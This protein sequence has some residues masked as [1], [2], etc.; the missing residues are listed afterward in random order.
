MIS[1]RSTHD[2]SRRRAV[3]AAVGA[4]ATAGV[5]SSLVAAPSGRAPSSGLDRVT[6]LDF[7]GSAAVKVTMRFRFMDPLP[8]YPATYL[9]WAYPRRQ[10]GYYTAFFWGNDD[11]R[12]DLRTFLWTSARTAD[13]YYGAHP[14]PQPPPRGTNHRWEISVLQED[15]VNGVV[16]YDRWHCQA[17]RVWADASGK[18]HEFY[19]D[20]PLT[21][22]PHRVAYKAPAS[23]GNVRPP[24]PTL[25]WGDAP[26]AP[27]KEVWNGV[28]RGIQVYAACLS[29]GDILR[30]AQAPRSTRSGATSLWYLNLNPTPQ[31]IADKSGHGHHPEWVGPE[32][33]AQWMGARGEFGAPW[34][35]RRVG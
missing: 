15:F 6:G 33:P 12:G 30:E 20:L 25:T 28:L 11:G 19:W 13:S 9:W 1:E 24:V 14:Y 34:P 26:W 31:D 23:W 8:I 5:Q 27:G 16:E 22:R 2:A 35:L 17:L 21:D 4:C 32:R 18:Y 3:M 10:A 7:P 29:V